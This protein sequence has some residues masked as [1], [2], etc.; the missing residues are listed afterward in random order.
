MLK[1]YETDLSELGFCSKK[2]RRQAEFKSATVLI[3][4][5]EPLFKF[6][7]ASIS[8]PAEGLE[9]LNILSTTDDVIQT[10]TARTNIY[11]DIII[12]FPISWTELSISKLRRC[13]LSVLAGR[14]GR[15]RFVQSDI[16]S[17][18][19][20]NIALKDKGLFIFLDLGSITVVSILSFP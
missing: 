5:F 6:L 3:D 17:L 4:F 20:T 12:T 15:L 10:L 9:K 2:D 14:Y 1:E 13:W 7:L 8:D 11:F 19:Q 18:S 16:A